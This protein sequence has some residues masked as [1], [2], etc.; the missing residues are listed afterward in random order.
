MFQNLKDKFKV[1]KPK[2]L[3]K[4]DNPNALR[5]IVMQNMNNKT[6]NV[7]EIKKDFNDPDI[8]SNQLLDSISR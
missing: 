2:P 7:K 1:F 8:V 4:I 5:N 6:K 3:E